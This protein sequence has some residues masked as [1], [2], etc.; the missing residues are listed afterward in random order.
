MDCLLSFS[1]VA[2]KNNYAKPIINNNSDLVIEEGRHPV[3]EKQLPNGEPYISN[4]VCLDRNRQQIMMI[5]GPN[6]SG[7]SGRQTAIVLMAQIGSFVRL[8]ET[9]G[10][11]DKIFTRVGASDNISLGESLLWLRC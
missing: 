3:I 2:S 5:T 4:N 1:I 10:I 6:M 9:I 7:K 8:Q 11:V